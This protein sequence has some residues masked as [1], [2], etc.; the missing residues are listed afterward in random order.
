MHD[1]E[2]VRAARP[3]TV[4][5][6]CWCAGVSCRGFHFRQTYIHVYVDYLKGRGCGEYTAEAVMSVGATMTS[7]TGG[8]CPLSTEHVIFP[9]HL[10]M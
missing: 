6:V 7:L 3:D 9:C 5:L 10:V 4:V 2:L 1:V 8:S